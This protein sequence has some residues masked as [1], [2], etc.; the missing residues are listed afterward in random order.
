M[1]KIIINKDRCKGCLL[2]VSFC[3]K[4]SIKVDNN[5]NRQGVKPV[6]FDDNPECLGCMMCAIICPD[7]CI[8]V[9]K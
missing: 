9:W 2:C 4:G 8:E 6:K 1:A 5:F 3:P 7:C